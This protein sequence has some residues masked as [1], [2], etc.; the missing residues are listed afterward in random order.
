MNVD[1]QQFTSLLREVGPEYAGVADSLFAAFDK[2]RGAKA[3]P[4]ISIV[5]PRGLTRLV[6]LFRAGMAG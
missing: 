2:N 6:L 1:R 5:A 3:P 4:P